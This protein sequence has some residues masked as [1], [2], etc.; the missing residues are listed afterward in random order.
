MNLQHTRTYL[1]IAVIVLLSATLTLN[2][3]VKGSAQSSSASHVAAEVTKGKLSPAES[4]PGDTVMVKLKDDVRS[5]GQ[6]VLKKGTE[7]TGIVRNVKRA[8][9]KGQGQSMM[10]IEW[11]APA[12]QAKAAQNLSFA[13]QS[14]TQTS[15]IYKYEQENAAAP[16]TGLIGSIADGLV[17]TTASVATTTVA[18]VDSAAGSTAGVITSNSSSST[19]ASGQSNTALLNMPSVVAA[20]QQTSSAIASSLGTTSSGQLFMLGHG[21]LITTGGSQQSLDIFSHLNNDNVITS[22][23]R[24]FEISSG[25]QMQFLVGVKK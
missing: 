1:L 25:A 21:Q 10:E 4:K 19:R 24:D 17:A 23:S 6:V 20:D 3:H 14:V 8:E 9:V 11:L 18:T 12:T 15:P 5:N 2:A 7:V 16:E 22:R 13:L